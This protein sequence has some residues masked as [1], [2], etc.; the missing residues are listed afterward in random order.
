MRR[1]P[2]AR[3]HATAIAVPRIHMARETGSAVYP[4]SV[5]IG[6]GARAK[7]ISTHTE[8]SAGLVQGEGAKRFR[9]SP[10]LHAPRRLRL[11]D[12]GPDMS[13]GPQHW[14]HDALLPCAGRCRG[15]H[16]A[17]PQ[18]AEHGRRFD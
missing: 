15:T 2:A 16:N 5:V 6:T 3:T 18:G 4:G 9:A 13:R 12:A 11:P 17:V 7:G 1:G 10:G 8:G 14:A